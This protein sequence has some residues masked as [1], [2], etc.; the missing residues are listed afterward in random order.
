MNIKSEQ[1]RIETE[2]MYNCRIPPERLRIWKVQ[3]DMWQMF[4]SV[5][6]KYNIKYFCF[7]GCLL[8]AAR[9]NG[10]VPWDTDIDI[11]MLRK[12][13]NR[14]VEVYTDE[15]KPPYVFEDFHI[16]NFV[17]IVNTETTSIS[18]NKWQYYP[19]NGINIDIFVLDGVPNK[20]YERSKISILKKLCYPK[21]V[22]PYRNIRI[23][24]LM[25]ALGFDNYLAKKLETFQLKIANT[26]Y[27]LVSDFSHPD[28]YYAEDFSDVTYLDFE[29]YNAPVPVGYLR[30][31]ESMYGDWKQ[32]PPIEVRQIS[33]EESK[34]IIENPDV[35]Y[36]I[37][38]SAFLSKA[39]EREK[40]KREWKSF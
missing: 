22:T 16:K 17:R 34:G 1:Q 6:R 27:P 40:W 30:I 10:F 12:D 8:G 5:C 38:E 32:L 23:R 13:F 7:W 14:L 18:P 15:F 28:K 20:R 26:A 11:V 24:K 39:K 33:E 2:K 36:Q 4:D 3:V 29:G 37:Y 25:R 19:H 31:L 9:H 35:P 21:D